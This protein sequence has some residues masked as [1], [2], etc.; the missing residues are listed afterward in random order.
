VYGVVAVD[1][2]VVPLGSKMWISGLACEFRAEDTGRLIRGNRLD[3]CLPNHAEARAWGVK[4]RKV[5]WK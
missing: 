1:P 5:E 4:Y 3:I 2:T